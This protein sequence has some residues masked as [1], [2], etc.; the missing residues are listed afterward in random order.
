MFSIK[1]FNPG[2]INNIYLLYSFNFNVHYSNIWAILL[3]G[4]K[5]KT[6][7]LYTTKNWTK[8]ASAAFLSRDVFLLPRALT[9]CLFCLVDDVK[10]NIALLTLLSVFCWMDSGRNRICQSQKHRMWSKNIF[11]VILVRRKNKLHT[12]LFE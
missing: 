11:Q 5:L 3:R 9:R 1:S 4:L 8:R 6:E 2:N 12:F 10:I 7:K